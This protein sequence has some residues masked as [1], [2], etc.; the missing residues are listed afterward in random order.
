VAK[1][2]IQQGNVEQQQTNGATPCQKT[3]RGG[4]LEGPIASQGEFFS[5]GKLNITASKT[6]VLRPDKDEASS[7]DNS[8]SLKGSQK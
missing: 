6:D 1:A 5:S 4:P 2:D 3:P 8:K 7:L